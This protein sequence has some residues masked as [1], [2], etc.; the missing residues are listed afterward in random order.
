M[1]LAFHIAKRYLV[2]KKSTNAINVISSVSV[3]GMI[4]GTMA[5]ILVLSVFNGFEDLVTSLYNTFN[6]HIK[7]TAKKGK[8]FEP[9][10]SKVLQIRALPEVAAASLVLEENALLQ[11]R[12][13][14]NFIARLKGV[15][16]DF[17]KV[18]QVD[19][20]LI[21][22]EFVLEDGEIDY[23]VLGLGVQN[24]LGVNIHNEFTPI[25]VY[26]PKRDVKVSRMRPE[27][28]FKQEMVYPSAVFAIQQDFDARYVIVP[29]RFMRSL[30]SYEKEV[31][32]IEISLKNE[33][34]VASVKKQIQ[35]ILGEG[36]D[37]KDRYE[38]DE[39]LYK[40]MSAEK[41]VV[42]LILSFILVVASFNIIG[43]LS[44]LVMEKKH[45]IGILKAMGATN[46]FIRKVFFMEGIM[47]SLSGAVIGIILATL[48]CLTQQHFEVIKLQGASFLIDAYPV[49]MRI[50]DFV[51]VFL[52][53]MVISILASIVPA[54]RAAE[55]S[56]L[57]KEE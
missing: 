14:N 51:L 17:T 45:D 38:Q 8:V 52:T 26:M 2:S 11:Y 22:G 37:I 23:A 30:L 53:V 19:T 33:E 25:K 24:I 56:Q 13:E 29:M 42:Y 10:N 47:L 57:I 28:A 16:D 48:I 46:N 54:Q 40:I 39:T 18:S 55:T 9:D 5:L 27:S 31:S 6:P 20:A 12:Q 44:M 7:I 34:N 35:A 3:V 43:S 36:F 41:W 4:V 1:N 21:D 49:S 15:D 32:S 50:G